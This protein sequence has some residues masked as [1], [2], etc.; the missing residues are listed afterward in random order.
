MEVHYNK[1]CQ[2]CTGK[3]VMH[4][5]S[6]GNCSICEGLVQTSHTPCDEVCGKCSAEKDLCMSCGKSLRPIKILKVDPIP[7][8][9]QIEEYNEN[10]P[11]QHTSVECLTFEEIKERYGVDMYEKYLNRSLTSESDKLFE[12]IEGYINSIVEEKQKLEGL[13]LSWRTRIKDTCEQ[14]INNIEHGSA[15]HQYDE[16]DIKR[17][18]EA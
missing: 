5:F 10:N 18:T 2:K 4:A 8:E 16:E 6:D 17:I 11:H 15:W 3:V 7:I 9:H 13:I 14:R 1:Y 12:N